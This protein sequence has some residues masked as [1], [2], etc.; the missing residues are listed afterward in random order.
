[1]VKL[2]EKNVYF[3]K[4]KKPEELQKDV[5]TFLK[6]REGTMAYQVIKSH[7]QGKDGKNL[8]IKFDSLT[9]HDITYVGIVQTARASGLERAATPAP[10]PDQQMMR[11]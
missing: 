2:V 7:D 5:E 10:L 9:S 11:V 8:K 6:A 1:M 3:Q 4:G